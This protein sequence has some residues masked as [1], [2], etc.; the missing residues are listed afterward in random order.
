MVRIHRRDAYISARPWLRLIALLLALAV[1]AAA[2]ADQSGFPDPSDPVASTPWPDY[3]LLRYDIIDQT[4]EMLGTVD[5]EIE[6]QGDEY[7]IRILFLLTAGAVRDERTLRVRADTL[8]PL[9]YELLA[10]DAEN[11]RIEARGT[12][13]VDDEGE[14][15]VDTVV[16]ENG[17]RDEKRVQTGQ[18]AF[19]TDSSAWLWRSIAFAQDH[20]VSYRSVNVRAQR[21]QLVRLR[22]VGQDLLSTPA[23]DILAWQLEARPGLEQQHIWFQ[24][25]RPNVLV[26]WDLQPRRYLLREIVTERPSE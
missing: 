23:G 22:V 3:E 8:E 21:S 14:P 6:R 12:Y 20:E 18:F 9:H 7:Q 10:T 24:V 4:D 13:G 17:K 16:I 1:L 11:N 2:C 26:R 15:I 19:D 25:D 5:F